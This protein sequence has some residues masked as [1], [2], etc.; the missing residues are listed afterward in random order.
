MALHNLW[1]SLFSRQAKKVIDRR[2]KKLFA[3]I[4]LNVGEIIE[5][6]DVNKDLVKKKVLELKQLAKD[7]H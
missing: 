5:P 2:P 6:K 3:K 7:E 1:G 4:S